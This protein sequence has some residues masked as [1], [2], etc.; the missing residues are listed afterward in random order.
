MSQVKHLSELI[1]CD[2]LGDKVSPYDLINTLY[3]T[4]I[5][6]KTNL[7]QL[8]DKHIDE[9]ELDGNIYSLLHVVGL[10]ETIAA[11]IVGACPSTIIIF[12]DERTFVVV[13]GDDGREVKYPIA[14]VIFCEEEGTAR[15]RNL[16]DSSHNELK[17]LGVFQDYTGALLKQEAA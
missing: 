5:S 3:F 1:D 4:L 17:V 7:K 15:L 9:P 6:V 14:E 12:P 13:E 16:N 2:Q 10:C 11:K 8:W